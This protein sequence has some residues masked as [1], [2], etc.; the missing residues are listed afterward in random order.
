M[1]LKKIGA[2][3][4]LDGEKEFKKAA[5]EI[6]STLKTMKSEMKLVTSE[7][8]TNANSMDALTA[9][10]E[11]LT[12]QYAK[13][14]QKVELL[15]DALV[16]SQKNQYK[17][18]NTLLD[19]RD[20]LEDAEEKMEALRKSSDA[21]TE[22][23]E[24]QEKEVKSLRGSVELAEEAY[25]KAERKVEYWERSLFD[26]K[27]EVNNLSSE[28][29]L[30]EKYLKEAE[31]TA[32][33]TAQSIDEFGKQVKQAGE[34][35]LKMGDIIKANLISE[36]VISGVKKLASAAKDVVTEVTATGMEF[37]S[38]FAGAKKTINATDGEIAQLR[39]EIIGMSTEIPA[40]TT[41]ISAVAEAAGQL[42]IQNENITKFTRTMIDMGNST[43]VVAEEAASSLAKF[44]NI[45]KMS[46]KDF[47]RL[48]STVVSLGNNF[49]TTEADIIAMGTRLAAAGSQVNMSEAEIMG[50]ATAL[51]SV[52]ME[53]EAG[54]SAFSKAMINIQLAVETGSTSLE[55][56]AEVA[57]MSAE[58][59]SRAWKE[60][61]AGALS[62]FITG[63]GDTSRLGSSTI[64]ILD[65]MGITE[66]RLRDSLLRASGASDVFTKA[67]ELGNE[68]WEKNTALTDEA[69]QRYETAESKTEILKNS[70][71]ALCITAYDRFRNS[72][73]AGVENATDGM[74]R[75]TTSIANG[76]LGNSIEKLG[77]SF[78][79]FAD[80]VLDFAEDAIPAVVDGLSWIMDNSKLITAGIAGIGA[81][82]VIN[83]G[84]SAVEKGVQVY[85]SLSAMIT[86][87][88]AATTAQTV[89]TSA[90]TA[91]TVTQTTATGAAAVAQTGLNAAMSAN[92]IGLVVTAVGGLVTALGIL[93]STADVAKSET[94]EYAE[95]M[96]LAREEA[97]KLQEQTKENIDTW[98]ESY[99]S[100][101]IQG[102][103]VRK[104]ADELIT[105]SEKENK[106][107]SD[108]RRMTYL[109]DELNGS[110]DGLNLTLDEETYAL[111]MSSDAIHNSI[112]A[113]VSYKKAEK[114]M[115]NA[116]EAAADL[117]EAEYNLSKA[118]EEAEKASEAVREAEERYNT[119]KDNSVTLS[120]NSTQAEKERYRE[121]AQS[122]MA[123]GD[124]QRAEE[125]AA[126]AVRIQEENVKEITGV[127]NTWMGI[128]GDTS[129]LE[130]A[131]EAHVELGGVVHTV[132]GEMAG[133]AQRLQEEYNRTY[134]EMEQSID[135]QI[136]LFDKLSLE[137]EMSIGEMIA[138][139]ESQSVAM[140]QWATNIQIAA[141][142]GINKGLL[143]EL[144]DGSVESAQILNEIVNSTDEEIAALNEAF[145]KTSVAKE[146]LV[147]NMAEAKTG[148]T[149]QVEA[150]IA[151]GNAIATSE[152]PVVG[153]NIVSGTVSG[154]KK[155]QETAINAIGSMASS[156]ISRFKNTMEIKSPSRVFE[157]ES[158]WIPEGAAKGVKEKG[159][160]AVTAIEDMSYQ[161][162]RAYN[163]NLV[164][165]A[166]ISP[167]Q[168]HGSVEGHHV[169]DNSSRNIQIFLQPQS[170]TDAELDRCFNYINR[171]LGYMGG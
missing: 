117:A 113:M 53:A 54:G 123:L 119:A 118:K 5:S 120:K 46:Q 50:L 155:H 57:G 36:A 135:G 61:A 1:A 37:E 89:A 43:N 11:V 47:D 24:E 148:Y 30:N 105:L 106:S 76:R 35:S 9:K 110:V 72:F 73:V 138:N 10:S 63:L 55:N 84:V 82:M 133:E 75:L 31:S 163:P 157:R 96:K 99:D 60:D 64:A 87:A 104:L 68:A 4:A 102:E 67:I 125:E 143:A 98:Q 51:S 103:G 116:A 167:D 29:K 90:Q 101:G 15:S 14:S 137:S 109:V 40:T 65:E 12:K 152:S 86:A 162:E 140:E 154:I 2:L 28:I 91:A 25:G 111:N 142:R 8:S 126:E 141:D 74:N 95:S 27:A 170:M 71:D 131:E 52:G 13:Q 79:G 44:A 130:S 69:N 171:R 129:S 17:I 26:A 114:A 134:S 158:E 168:L 56:Y 6:N 92:P 169:A 32:D 80:D 164:S 88:S 107:A 83:K 7:Y 38:A 34:E 58:E 132:T 139:L 100:I 165:N 128:A 121:Y 150:M 81:A 18:H 166:I 94:E 59:F 77:R 146:T 156:M 21:T 112:N 39:E 159:E 85:R 16:N 22:E 145:E 62:T 33:G 70:V 78:E 49:A 153:E 160:V 147:T 161:M 41:E 66:V 19:Y 42:G 144:D 108:K 20:A 97:E 136:G 23:L 3:L 45:T 124:L 122:S 115:D 127:Y 151:E 48:G 93:C 149:E